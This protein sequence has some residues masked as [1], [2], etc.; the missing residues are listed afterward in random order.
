VGGRGAAHH[1][2]SQFTGTTLRFIFEKQTVMGEWEFPLIYGFKQ[3]EWDELLQRFRI[4]VDEWKAGTREGPRVL[5]E[6]RGNWP[7][8][9]CAPPASPKSP[10]TAR[11][12]LPLETISTRMGHPTAHV[13]T[14]PS[15]CPCEGCAALVR[16][17]TPPNPKPV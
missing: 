11:L 9:W 16:A 3:D 17:T 6:V 4:A 7:A 1:L 15:A 5:V 10:P 13:P 8:N 12:P 2:P 14:V